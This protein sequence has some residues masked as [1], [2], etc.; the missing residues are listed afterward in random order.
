[1]N[2]RRRRRAATLIEQEAAA[3]GSARLEEIHDR[4]HVRFLVV[5]Q[6]QVFAVAEAGA[7]EIKSENAY[8]FGKEDWDDGQGVEAAARVAVAVAGEDGFNTRKRFRDWD[9][10]AYTTQGTGL[11]GG[12]PLAP[13]GMK[14]EHLR[15]WPAGVTR[16]VRWRLQLPPQLPLTSGVDELEVLSYDVHVKG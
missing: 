2:R 7:R 16:G 4:G 12:V 1:L 13:H 3:A 5:P 10:G 6:A 14:R 9:E 15:T 8:V 11:G